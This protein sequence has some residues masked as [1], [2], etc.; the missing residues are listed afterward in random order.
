MR[1]TRM[2]NPRRRRVISL[3][4]LLSDSREYNERHASAIRAAEKYLVAHPQ[5]KQALDKFLKIFRRAKMHGGD[6]LA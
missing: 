6:F 4:R 5:F 2:V 1:R 3:D